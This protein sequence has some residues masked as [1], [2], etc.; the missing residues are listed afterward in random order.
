MIRFL[1]RRTRAPDRCKRPFLALAAVSNRL[2]RLCQRTNLSTSSRPR[3]RPAAARRSIPARSTLCNQRIG[4]RARPPK[5][6]PGCSRRRASPSTRSVL[7]RAGKQ[8]AG[9]LAG[10]HRARLSGV[11]R[12]VR[13]SARR[14]LRRKGAVLLLI[15]A[16]APPASDGQSAT[17]ATSDTTTTI[18]SE[19]VTTTTIPSETVTTTIPTTQSCEEVAAVPGLPVTTLEELPSS[20][21]AQLPEFEETVQEA[22]GLPLIVPIDLPAAYTWTWQPLG[23]NHPDIYTYN[24]DAQ[25]NSTPDLYPLTIDVIGARIHQPIQQAADI[26]S[27]PTLKPWPDH[28]SIALARW[29]TRCSGSRQAILR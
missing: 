7:G 3:A 26:R 5:S 25:S 28:P 27:S 1:L 14:R 20:I 4:P 23:G 8:V 21:V 24:A 11:I 12:A 2:G 15:I 16:C 10:C 13:T 29:P 17:S 19:T 9:R 6:H 22:C 18:P